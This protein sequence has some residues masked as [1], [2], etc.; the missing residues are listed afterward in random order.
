MKNDT[1]EVIA[2]NDQ[3]KRGR[4]LQVVPESGKVLVEGVRY[5]WRHVRPSQKNP[6]GGRVQKE[7][8]LDASNV[9]VVCPS[10]DKGVKVSFQGEKAAKIRV[11]SK[12]G[13]EIRAQG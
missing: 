1:V 12:C 6:Q 4:V 5:I 3:G 13:H 11:C 8:L 2:G 10:C 9:L 7:A